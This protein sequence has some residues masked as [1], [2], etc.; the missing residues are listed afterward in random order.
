MWI[1]RNSKPRFRGITVLLI[2]VLSGLVAVNVFLIIRGFAVGVASAENAYKTAFAEE[3]EKTAQEYYDW[4]F[5]KAERE[6]HTSNQVKISIGE[7]ESRST[8]EVLR[9]SD[10][11][12]VLQDGED[13]ESE[14]TA[15]VAVPGDGVFTVDMTMSE[16]LIDE[17]RHT[18]VARVPRPELT[19]CKTD[20]KNVEIYEL[21]TGRLRNGNYA[22]GVSL[23][24]EHLKKGN[25][26][27]RKE[28]LSNQQYFLRARDSAEALITQLILNLNPEIPDLK[29]V[30]EFMEEAGGS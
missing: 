7:I 8:L 11:E 16:F 4:A 9:V 14:V 25:E 28:F 10:V 15:W 13:G 12:F 22:E 29:V 30:V 19:N 24:E 3:S 18:V 21:R 26:M 17:K 2:L 6:Y 27:I 23:A 20:P 1:N 5:D